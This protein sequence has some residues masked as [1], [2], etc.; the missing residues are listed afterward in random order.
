MSKPLT[1]AAFEFSGSFEVRAGVEGL[2]AL[3]KASELLS[4]VMDSVT[5]AGMGAPLEG[6][7]A[8]LVHHSLESAKALIDALW[9]E[10]QKM[11]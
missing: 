1:T 2:K 6:N 9:V 5:D 3:T 4:I 7:Q 11:Q 10:Q 8:W